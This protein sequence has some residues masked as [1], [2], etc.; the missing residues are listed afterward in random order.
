MVRTQVVL[1]KNAVPKYLGLKLCEELYEI[2]AAKADEC[3]ENL[4]D[5]GVRLLAEAVKRPDLAVV[6]RKKCG[7]ARPR[8]GRPRK[9][10][11]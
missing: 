11:S 1:E 7:G 10:A 3:G 9:V 4:I 5:V 2:V 8:A 6:P